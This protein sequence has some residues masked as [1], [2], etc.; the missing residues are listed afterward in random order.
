MNVQLEVTAL[1]GVPHLLHALLE[2]TTNRSSD[3]FFQIVFHVN[4][5]SIVLEL[6]SL[7]SQEIAQAVTTVQ[8]DHQVL[9]LQEQ[10]LK[11]VSAR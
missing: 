2:L 5:E 1:L 9:P 8:E 11:E 7:L 10:Q 6:V 4:Q 3:Q